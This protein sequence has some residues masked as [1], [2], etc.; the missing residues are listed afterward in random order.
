MLTPDYSGLEELTT[1]SAKLKFYVQELQ[2]LKT[3]TYPALTVGPAVFLSKW[4]QKQLEFH[5]T[6][7]LQLGN[8]C[9]HELIELPPPPKAPQTLDGTV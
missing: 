9:I 4:L 2:S 8:L 1:E 7:G 5:S 3:C 6:M